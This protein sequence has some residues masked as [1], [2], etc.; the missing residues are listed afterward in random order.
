MT[1]VTFIVMGT[2]V[3]VYT[4]GHLQSLAIQ[5][6]F[7]RVFDQ[8]KTGPE[9]YQAIRRAYRLNVRTPMLLIVIP[10]WWTSEELDSLEGIWSELEPM[11]ILDTIPGTDYA[12]VVRILETSGTKP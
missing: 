2:L 9:C 12:R 4:F 6:A 10:L 3:S 7:F 11:G 1:T 8:A 5:A